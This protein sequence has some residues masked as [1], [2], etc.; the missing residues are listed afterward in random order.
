[1]LSL[2]LIH[3]ARII[4][5]LYIFTSYILHDILLSVILKT[6]FLNRENVLQLS[7]SVCDY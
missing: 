5:F 4:T 7:F 6:F 3:L 1:M 2:D